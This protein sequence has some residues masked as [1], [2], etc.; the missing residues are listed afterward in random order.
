MGLLQ[1]VQLSSV[2]MLSP[3][4]D[5]FS[6]QTGRQLLMERKSV[7]RQRTG[8]AGLPGRS[9]VAIPA[10][11]DGDPQLIFIFKQI[12]N[13]IALHLKPA[14]AG[15]PAGAMINSPTRIPFNSASYTPTQVMRNTAFCAG[16]PVNTLRNCGQP[17]VVSGGQIHCPFIPSPSLQYFI[18]S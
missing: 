2:P 12:G 5:Q 17:S 8:Q 13:I 11:T 1:T 3:V 18:S 10:W 9:W 14:A 4:D 7:D 6:Q 16:W 15:R